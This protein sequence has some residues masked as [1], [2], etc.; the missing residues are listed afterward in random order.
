MVDATMDGRTSRVTDLVIHAL[1]KGYNLGDLATA[2]RVF[3]EASGLRVDW[4]GEEEGC[5]G[6]AKTF[7]RGGG[8]CLK[9]S[10][11]YPDHPD[12]PE[13]DR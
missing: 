2:R 4:G 7:R 11:F 8:G 9:T 6:Y 13:Q 3:S 12:H 5:S 1:P 10:Y